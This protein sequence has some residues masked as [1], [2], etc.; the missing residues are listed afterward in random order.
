[1]DAIA[2][3]EI[4]NDIGYGS[5]QTTTRLLELVAK[6]IDFLDDDLIQVKA[7][8]SS[9][10]DLLQY[11]CSEEGNTDS[12]CRAIDYVLTF[13][14]DNLEKKKLPI[15]LKL[16]I[17]D[18]MSSLHDAHKSPDIAKLVNALPYQL[19]ERINKLEEGDEK[20]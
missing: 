5:L 16:I 15:Q 9:L 14:Y 7:L 8:Q 3:K 6:F 19:L 11:L 13:R 1:M 17:E 12:N 20:D 4:L 18:M 2:I 10:K